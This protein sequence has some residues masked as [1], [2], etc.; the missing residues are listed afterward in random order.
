ME[1][2]KDI[3]QFH[4]FLN[5]V[6]KTLS[7]PLPGIHAQGKMAPPHRPIELRIPKQGDHVRDSAVFP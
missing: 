4:V 5:K 7:E 1:P 6:R 2:K 3:I